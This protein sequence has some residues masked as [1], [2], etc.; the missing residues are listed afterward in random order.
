MTSVTEIARCFGSGLKG[1]ALE[2]HFCR[3]L[4]PK[5]KLILDALARGE[6]PGTVDLDD[7]VKGPKGRKG[8]M[9]LILFPFQHVF[10]FLMAELNPN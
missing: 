9:L 10:L 4:K 7:E 1:H 8:Q 3:H 2:M 6:D 5:S